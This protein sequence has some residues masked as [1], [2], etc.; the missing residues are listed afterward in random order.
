[1]SGGDG[2]PGFSAVL[3]AGGRS[4]RM[5][6]DKAEIILPDG[7]PLWRRQLDDV[8]RP[9]GPAEIFFSG[10]VRAGLPAE[11]RVLTDATPGLGPLSGLAA[12]LGAASTTTGVS[13][14]VV[15]AVDLPAM[16]AGFFRDRLLPICTP[17]RG[18]V[19]VGAAGHFEPLAAV[20]PCAAHGL[21]MEHL[22]GAN[23]SLRAFVQAAQAA[24][25]V[26][27]W[28]P[29][30]TA[31]ALFTNW[32]TPQDVAGRPPGDEPT[33]SWTDKSHRQTVRR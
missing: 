26:E 25:L 21:A 12:A 16:T 9:L 29:D 13:L 3:L 27:P 24:G 8:L 11:V 10:P 15:L 18:A 6:Q 19:P 1:M 20:Y 22:R 31:A 2:H 23:R 14:V 7:R 30:G 28:G 17:L 5:G 32:N 33:R 4:V